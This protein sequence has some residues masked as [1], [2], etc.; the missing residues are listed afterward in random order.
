MVEL[1][2]DQIAQKTEGTILQGSPS[3]CFHRFNIDSRQTEP[4]EL[5]FAMKARRDGHSFVPDAVEKGAA[6]AVVSQKLS[7]PEKK[8]GLILVRDTLMALQDLAR[9]VL[10]AHNIKVV[11]ITGST[12]KTTT[13]EFLSALL[14]SSLNVLKSEGNFNNELG[15]P[16][17][18]LR[19]NE[20]HQVAVLEMA[21]S[22]K[23]EIKAL[24]EI[25]PPDVAVITNINPVHLEFFK[26]IGEIAL[27]KREILEGL[28]KGGTAVLNGDD[29]RVHEIAADWKGKRI[30][31]GF[32]PGCDI[33]VQ[34][35]QKQGFEGMRFELLYGQRQ[36]DVLFPFFLESFLYDFLAASAAAYALSLPVETVSDKAK[37]LRPIPKRGVL[38]SLKGNIKLFDDSYNSNPRALAAVLEGLAD[39]RCKRKVAVLGD[40]L[41]L[42]EEGTAFHVQAGKQVAKWGWDC[43][44]TVGSLSRHMA[45]G[46]QSAGMKRSD[47]HSFKDS[48]EAAEA[49]LDIVRR[50]DLILVKGSRSIQ[51]ERIVEK[52]KSRGT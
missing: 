9:K 35:I 12:G 26:S 11:G 24:T 14:S 31:F 49:I 29:S 4:G 19:L 10:Q 33:R 23:G 2:L 1:R 27:A 32:S 50:G 20:R 3:L 45:K 52:L 18:L 40:M 22:H 30:T 51:T 46:A 36:K 15:L 8:V 7:L 17:S 28:K 25:A 6:G 42:G 13:K 37:S 16:L 5:F 39:L 38:L 34:N 48:S 47:I 21:M 44:V 43:L 41:E